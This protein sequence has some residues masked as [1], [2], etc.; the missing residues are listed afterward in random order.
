MRAV[1]SLYWYLAQQDAVN[2]A[3]LITLSSRTYTWRWTTGDSEIVSSS[4]T[5]L[6]FPGG[7]GGGIEESIDLGIATINF[8]IVNSGDDFRLLLEANDLDMASIIVR[9]V[10]VSTPDGGSAEIYRGKVGDYTFNRQQISGQARNFFNS[11]NVQ[12]PMYTYM[13]QCAWRFGSPGCGFNTASI[14]VS[15]TA[16]P[17]SSGY[18]LGAFCAIDSKS[19][20]YYEKGRFTFTSG[21]NSGHA[22]SVRVHSGSR[23]EFSHGMPYNIASGD[24]FNLYPGCRKRIIDDC[25]STYNNTRNALAFPWISKVENAF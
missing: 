24:T 2:V 11:I 4:Y 15:S 14:T 1:S 6:P 22:R 23:V 25:T 5:F 20:G 21:S 3:E 8:T 10:H 16:S 13:D 7:T 19:N 17:V 9:R 12:W 18:K